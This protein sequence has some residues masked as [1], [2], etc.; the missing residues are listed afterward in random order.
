VK[1]SAETIM[2]SI[3]RTALALAL[4]PLNLQAS[5]VGGPGKITVLPIPETPQV[6][7]N[8]L[9]IQITDIAD[10]PVEKATVTVGLFMIAM[11][12]MPRMEEKGVVR[13]IGKGGYEASYQVPMGGSWEIEV[14]V[15]SSATAFTSQ[16]SITT[17]IAGIAD[18]NVKSSGANLAAASNVLN[19]GPLRLQ[20]I[21]V[22][23]AIAKEALLA[24]TIRAV[25]L[26]EQD[27]T[28]RE[29]VTVRYSGYIAK[30]FSGRVGDRVEKGQEL[31][32][33]YSP[34]LVTAQSEYILAAKSAG[35]SK[36]LLMAAEDRLRN[37]GLS[38]LQIARLIKDG[39][40]QRDMLVRAP[41]KGTIL[42]IGASEGS[43]VSAGQSVIVIG[44]LDK[45]Y[46]V[47]RVF[48]QDVGD[49]KAGQT[50]EYTIP[51][52]SSEIQNGVV[53]LVFP[54]IEQGTGTANVRVQ[55]K[56]FSADLKPGTYVDLRFLVNIGS[57]LTIP[58]DAL[59]YSGLHN[60][61]FVDQGEGMLEPREVF[62]GRF[63]ADLVEIRSGLKAGERV[64]ASGNFL[65]SSE[66]QLRSALPK[67][68]RVETP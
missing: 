56:N 25:G 55:S 1:Y 6:G 13:E 12:S 49:I 8:K 24:R 31:F 50:A 66:A 45:G 26:V 15:E 5:A 54:Q 10:Q 33:I 22:R 32:S 68:S 37:L 60:Y 41:I 43:S 9:S 38:E 59:I 61:V 40:P 14:K 48:Q 65:L 58:A 67:W 64:A 28:H 20:K 27:K 44:D 53:D 47:A 7:E 21:G 57:R 23:F 16:Y 35:A 11:G 3:A 63:V 19:I 51:S 29:D 36:S 39:K 17:D 2:K 34:D 62:P 4:G 18:K 42:E 52:V 30:L 46:I